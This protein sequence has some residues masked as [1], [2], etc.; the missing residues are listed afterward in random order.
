MVKI[1]FHECWD[2]CY[3]VSW[4]IPAENKVCFNISQNLTFINKLKKKEKSPFCQH[5]G[6]FQ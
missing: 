4:I 6:V 5:C 1:H 3:L 2:L